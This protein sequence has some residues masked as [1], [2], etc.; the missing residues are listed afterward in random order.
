[1]KVLEKNID[2]IASYDF[3]NKKVFG[4]AYFVYKK[5]KTLEKCYGTASLDKN[6]PITN[7]S[8][9]RLASMTK[10]VTAFATLI[11]VERGK[12]A[13]DD[14]IDKYLPEFK[15][16]KIIYPTGEEKAPKEIPTIKNLLTH[17]SG[18]SGDNEKLKN[19]TT[20][21]KATLESSIAYYLKIGLDFEPNSKQAYSGISAFDVLTKIIEIVSGTDFL[22]FLKKEIFEPCKMYDTTFTPSEEQWTRL[23]DMHTRIDGE[24][25]SVAMP[26]GCVFS[27]IPCTHFLGGA[28][29]VSSLADY[30]KFA[31]MLLNK[32]KT[33]SGERLISEET[34]NL[35]CSPQVQKEI[36]PWHTRWG[37]GVRVIVE[38]DHPHLPVRSFGWSGAYGS[39]FWIDPTN[40]IYAIFMKNSTVDGGSGNESAENFEKAVY[41]SLL[42]E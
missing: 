25:S 3:S 9:F 31:K 29:L 27:D 37:L 16:I 7:N 36:M 4:S 40:E 39:H 20:Y 34:F 35:L 41:S 18:I 5:G 19:M 17:T 30:S 11:L 2:K 12:L 1:M 33:E 26:V 32:G 23:V 13:L 21:D 8:L 6:V 10:P 28:G 22:S 15:T 38:N 14:T 42:E 24:N